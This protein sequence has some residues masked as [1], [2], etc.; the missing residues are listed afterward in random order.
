MIEEEKLMTRDEK[1]KQIV[2]AG[3]RMKEHIEI[4]TIIT[5]NEK[6]H[7][8][9]EEENLKKIRMKQM[10]GKSRFVMPSVQ[11]LEDYLFSE[12]KNSKRTMITGLAHG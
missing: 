2:S 6:I 12:K 7:K 3:S 4:A 10:I 9:N 5:S 8:S 11:Q 1:R